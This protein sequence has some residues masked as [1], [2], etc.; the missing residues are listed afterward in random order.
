MTSTKKPKIIRNP[1]DCPT[2]LVQYLRNIWHYHKDR[3]LDVKTHYEIENPHGVIESDVKKH[4]EIEDSDGVIK[5]KAVEDLTYDDLAQIVEKEGEYR[6]DRRAV[7]TIVEQGSRQTIEDIQDCPIDVSQELVAIHRKYK[8]AKSEYGYS[9]RGVREVVPLGNMTPHH[10]ALYVRGAYGHKI[11]TRTVN[12]YVNGPDS[13]ADCVADDL[14]SMHEQSTR[15]PRS[16]TFEEPDGT[17]R[18]V[19]LH[20]L[21]LSDKARI[22]GSRHGY[23]IGPEE[24]EKLL[25]EPRL[26]V[27]RT[28][29]Y[30]RP[31]LLAMDRKDLHGCAMGDN[32]R[33]RSGKCDCDGQQAARE[34]Q[35]KHHGDPSHHRHYCSQADTIQWKSTKCN[36]DGKITERGGTIDEVVRGRREQVMKHGHQ[37][38]LAGTLSSRAKE[39]PPSMPLHARSSSHGHG[40]EQSQASSAANAHPH[41]TERATRIGAQGNT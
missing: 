33:W 4:Y 31:V 6:I 20:A 26:S 7:G 27:K 30:M 40:P 3:H 14:L 2:E 17:K 8:H 15:E 38:G 39:Q 28:E 22:V 18:T 23:Q 34:E 21:T 25:A 32:Y 41:T 24:V 13:V 1:K 29:E 16:Y 11:A 10:S 9:Q 19:A 5:V 37:A 35:V 12:K 36:C